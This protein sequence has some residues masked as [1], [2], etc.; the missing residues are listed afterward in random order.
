MLKK[1][2]KLPIVEIS[3]AKARLDG[4]D[5]LFT[6]NFFIFRNFFLLKIINF[7]FFTRT[8]IF[9]GYFAMDK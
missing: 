1:E 9:R 6:G 8:R 2:L 5:V 7:S 3:D 4:G